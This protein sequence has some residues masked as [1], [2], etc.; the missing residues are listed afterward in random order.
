MK[1]RTILI[2]LIALTFTLFSCK[3]DND[4]TIDNTNS[5]LLIGEWLR[6]DSTDNFQYKLVFAKNNDGIIIN[7]QTI[8]EGEVTSNAS[9]F[10]WEI[11]NNALIIST[12]D[13]SITTTY[14][15]YSENQVLLN[16]FSELLFNKISSGLLYGKKE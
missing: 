11:E 14:Q 6:S 16:D 12:E 5:S 2:L 10:K 9:E 8:R 4:S 1:S 7:S 13:N 15:F 3:K